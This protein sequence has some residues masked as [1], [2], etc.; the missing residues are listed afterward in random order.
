MGRLEHGVGFAHARRIAKEDLQ[1]ARRFVVV[2]LVLFDATQKIVGIAPQALELHKP[3]LPL[4]TNK[5]AAPSIDPSRKS[6]FVHIFFDSPSQA[7][8]NRRIVAAVRIEMPGRDSNGRP[9]RPVM[10]PSSMENRKNLSLIH[11]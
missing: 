10:R 3:S 11:I 7:R 4:K 6:P 9:K 1:T 5:G 2:L 8:A